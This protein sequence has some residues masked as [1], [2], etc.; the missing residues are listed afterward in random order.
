MTFGRVLYFGSTSPTA[1]AVASCVSTSVIVDFHF[2]AGIFRSNS[3]SI[4]AD[5]RLPLVS[6]R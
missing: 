2:Q 4:S 6:H 3:S 5:D 1:V